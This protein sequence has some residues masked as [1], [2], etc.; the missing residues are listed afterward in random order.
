[1]GPEQSLT[2]LPNVSS[3]QYLAPRESVVVIDACVRRGIAAHV[4]DFYKIALVLA[5]EG[6]HIYGTRIEALVAGDVLPIDPSI[7]HA[8]AVTG[9]APLCV[10]N[11]IFTN[12]TEA[13]LEG[14]LDS[15]EVAGYA[16]TRA[17]RRAFAVCF[18]TTPDAYRRLDGA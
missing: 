16:D 8:F 10:C 7:P 5:G 9:G 11:V 4:H 6:R 18:R 12:F 3:A 15:P 13:A 2:G 14:A 1:M 17:L